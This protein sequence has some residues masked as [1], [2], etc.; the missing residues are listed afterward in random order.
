MLVSQSHRVAFAHYPKTA[1]SSLQ[2]WFID[3]FPD[4]ALLVPDNPH[5]PVA[6]SLQILRPHRWQRRLH[7]LRSR[8]LALVTPG[9]AA[10]HRPWHGGLR[11]VG[12]MR[13]P[14][15]MLVSLYEF[16]QREPFATPPTDPFINCARYGRFRDFLAAAVIGG[17]VDPYDRFFDVGGPAWPDTVLLDF[18]SIEPALQALSADL[19]IPQP[20][21]LPQLNR[22]PAGHRDLDRFRDEA[23]PLLAEVRRHF[24]W[25]YEEGVY[26]MRRGAISG[27]SRAA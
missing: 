24:R 25:Y 26:L 19:G 7:R 1:G 23:G 20:K 13:E 6:E 4:A 16:W 10:T 22:S 12:A 2:R 15:E 14:F 8:A 5:L 21:P 18:A 11:I 3:A 17:R 27:I 9:A